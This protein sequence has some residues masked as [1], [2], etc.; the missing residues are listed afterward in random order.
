MRKG[1]NILDIEGT[2]NSICRQ[3]QIVTQESLQFIDLTEE[4]KA[5]VWESGISNG[6]VNVQTRHTTTAII[7]NEHEP[8]LLADMKDLLERIVPG[9]ID[10]RHDDFT[11][12]TANLTPDERRNGFA[13]CRALFMRAA[14]CIN[15]LDGELQLG[16]WQRIFLL[17]LD[18]PRERNV[19]VMILGS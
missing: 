9:H 6:F 12:R 2:R 3:I 4:I 19:S 11:I 18:G 16:V 1:A 17:E 13:H 15:L 14:E 5:M 7:I 10:Y 8:L